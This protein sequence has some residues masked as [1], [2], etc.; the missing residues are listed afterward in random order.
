[1]QTDA[2]ARNARREGLERMPQ[3]VILRMA[4]RLEV[5]DASAF[6]WECETLILP[7]K[8]LPAPD[9]CA[10]VCSRR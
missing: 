8:T 2:L 1:M 3:G 9:A 6:G 7:A 10:Q 4:D 5:P